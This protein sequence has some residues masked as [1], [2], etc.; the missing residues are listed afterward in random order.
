MGQ[1][2]ASQ[3]F[4]DSLS[5]ALGMGHRADPGGS[6]TDTANYMDIIPEST[7]LSVG[8]HN[9]HSGN[10][11]Q[12][13][14]YLRAFR[15]ALIKVDWPSIAFA[16]NPNVIESRYPKPKPQPTGYKPPTRPTT[17]TEFTEEEKL[18][19]DYD[20]NNFT[21]LGFQDDIEARSQGPLS[22]KDFFDD[23]NKYILI[24]GELFPNEFP[25]GNE[26]KLIKELIKEASDIPMEN[27][28]YLEWF[29]S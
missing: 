7:N 3:E 18:W 2:C 28:E 16:R 6:F 1:L 15:D 27:F 8:Y 17:I 24:M 20:R 22:V 4:V 12:E 13:I 9:A 25:L 26:N 5:E 11:N 19:E 14:I 29:F 21:E 23:Y 10:E